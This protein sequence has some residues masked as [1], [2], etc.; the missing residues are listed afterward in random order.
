MTQDTVVYLGQQALMVTLL[1]SAPMLASGLVVGLVV[2][3]FQAATQVQE[4][5]L[6]FIPKIVVVLLS[7]LL[8]LPFMMSTMLGFVTGLFGGFNRF[9]F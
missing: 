5:T 6:T 4:I 1:V 3:V 9:V 8:F 2:S 7:F